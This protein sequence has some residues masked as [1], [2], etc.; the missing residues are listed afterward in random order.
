MRAELPCDILV[1]FVRTAAFEDAAVAA[2]ALDLLGA[3]EREILVRCR[4]AAARRDYLAAH[5]LVWTTLAELAGTDPHRLR[6]RATAGGRPEP[7][8]PESACRL[9]FSLSHADGLALCAVT[10]DGKVG[11]DVESLR[12]LG[13]D[14]LG[15]AGLV[16][17]P[18]EMQ[19]LQALPATSQADRLLCLWTVKEA[20]AKATGQ[21]F[22]LPLNRLAINGTTALPSW[23]AG[24]GGGWQWVSLRLE[25][26]YVIS[27]AVPG[28]ATDPAE[29]R[30]EEAVPLPPALR[31][32]VDD[33]RRGEPLQF[34]CRLVC[35]AGL[36]GSGLGLLPSPGLAG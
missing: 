12:N 36:N 11:A 29:V 16:C 22:R 10:R 26:C 31:E 18:G 8:A 2:Q 30:V 33:E 35:L 6:F 9:Q 7:V 20:V 27:V 1:R 24:E 5:A 21:G 28:T 14:P 34:F 3:D 13:P 17:A 25:P 15:V 23:L 32:S 4:P 19:A